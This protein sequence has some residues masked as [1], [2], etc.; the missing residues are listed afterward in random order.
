MT[1]G[2]APGH[3]PPGAAAAAAGGQLGAA[4]TTAA[5]GPTFPL[6]WRS[7]A[8][9]YR[10]GWQSTCSAWPAGGAGRASG[11]C[12]PLTCSAA[13]LSAAAHLDSILEHPFFGTMAANA[14]TSTKGGPPSSHV[15]LWR[16]AG[17]RWRKKP[18]GVSGGERL[19]AR[20]LTLT[21]LQGVQL[22]V[23]SVPGLSRR[24][25]G[26]KQHTEG[27]IQGITGSEHEIGFLK[28]ELTMIGL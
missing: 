6:A 10:P 4:G 19:V 28:K 27:E 21:S 20:N 7:N 24:I 26:N 16:R 22:D 1:R 18:P 25:M 8:Q 17:G 3:S 5:R 14:V 13:S 12:G 9:A 2:L 15:T 23:F 11:R